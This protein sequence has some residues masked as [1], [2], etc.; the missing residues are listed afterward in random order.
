MTAV[1]VVCEYAMIGEL[2]VTADLALMVHTWLLL[3]HPPYQVGENLIFFFNPDSEHVLPGTDAKNKQFKHSFFMRFV[4][5]KSTCPRSA[6]KPDSVRNSSPSAPKPSNVSS[7]FNFDIRQK[8]V[9]I[10][11]GWFVSPFS[12]ISSKPLQFCLL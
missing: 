4:L 10:G 9:V 11:L 5:P 7:Y 3:N 2:L 12:T 1:E 8:S 6:S